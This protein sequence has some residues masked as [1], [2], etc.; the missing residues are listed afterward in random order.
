MITFINQA[1]EKFIFPS[2]T[3]QKVLDWCWLDGVDK[4]SV[5]VSL[6]AQ[7]ELQ[8]NLVPVTN[9]IGE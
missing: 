8:K 5:K 1:S 9:G 6:A 3:M 7:I 2:V 4:D